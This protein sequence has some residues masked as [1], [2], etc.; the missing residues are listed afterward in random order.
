[1]EKGFQMLSVITI[2]SDESSWINEYIPEL[3]TRLENYSKEVKSCHSVEHIKQ[4]DILFILSFSKIIPKSK[5][6][7]N[8]NNIVV[9]ESSL[10]KGKG[11]S[12]LTWQILEGLSEIPITLFEASEKVDSGKIYLTDIMNFNGHELVQDLRRKQAEYTLKLCHDFVKNYP[13]IIEKG[14]EQLGEES[15]YKKRL[16]KDSKLDVNKTILEQFNLLRVVDNEK[17]PAYFE[18]N[19]KEYILKIEE[20]Q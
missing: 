15:F 6:D 1:M 3:K 12:P 4:G 7:L 20:K 19:G 8:R 10:P 5:L 18:L 16:P 11:W 14:I 13:R 2:L 17:Y 9:H